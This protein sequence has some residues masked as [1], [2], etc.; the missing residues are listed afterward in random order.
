MRL[1]AAAARTA[2]VEPPLLRGRAFPAALA[3]STLFFATM[4]GLMITVVLHPE[5]GLP[6]GPLA[7][8]LTLLPRSVGLA[9]AS[10]AA[11]ARLVPRDGTR[12]LHAGLATIAAGPAA[13]VLAR[14]AAPAAPAPCG[15][16]RR[17]YG[18]C[19]RHSG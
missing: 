1:A 8:G 4:N 11:G 12:V 3:T 15:G 16:R 6:R 5:L 14:R 7:T 10:R 18:F 9:A 2:L 19:R 13:A 17:P